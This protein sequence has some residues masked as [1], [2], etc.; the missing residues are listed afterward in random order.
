M[1]VRLLVLLALP[2]LAYYLVMSLRKRF[3][4][5]T[6]Q[7]QI[8]FF[9]VVVLLAVAVMILLGRLPLH[10]ILAPLGAAVA[11]VLRFLPTLL[12]LL[13]FWGM[14][15]SKVAGAGAYT[16]N[17]SSKI[18]TK[19]LAMELDHASGDL[20]GQVLQGQFA[21]QKLSSLNLEQLVA[22]YRECASDKDSV[23]ILEAYLDRSQPD[24]REQVG[25]SSQHADMNAESTMTRELALEILGL[26]GD[27]D[28]DAVIKAHRS[29]MQKMHPDRGGSSYLAQK[30]N[31]AKD[32]L[33]E[34]MK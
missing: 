11:F 3:S 34:L 31:A 16:S 18:R 22:L 17:Q 33:L 26:E 32:F 25:A 13:P 19:F 1:I 9:I 30:I 21:S 6:R 4:L 23:Q 28:K 7:T 12:R 29:L 24:W 2:V 10:F 20:D 27:P 8:L 5:T 15:R 14:F